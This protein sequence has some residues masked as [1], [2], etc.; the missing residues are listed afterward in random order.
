M[1]T[2][3]SKANMIVRF[4][5][6][7][8]LV[9]NLMK[10]SYMG[11]IRSNTE[12]FH[13]L[14]LKNN[15]IREEVV[16]L[17][18]TMTGFSG[19]FLKNTGQKT[20]FIRYYLE[21]PR[22]SVGFGLSQLWYSIVSEKDKSDTHPLRGERIAVTHLSV[23]FS[24]S[25]KILPVAEDMT[26]AHNNF[27]YGSDETKW[28]YSN[29]YYNKLIYHNIYDNID[30]VYEIMENQL[31]YNFIV[32]PGGSPQSIQ[33]QWNGPVTLENLPTGIQI[34]VKSS[35]LVLTDSSP[36]IYQ[37]S[38]NHPSIEGS[39]RLINSHTYGFLIPSYDPRKILIIDPVILVT[40]TYV[41]GVSTDRGY[42]LAVDAAG[43]AWVTGYTNSDNFPVTP[44]AYDSVYNTTDIFLLKYNGNSGDLEYSTFIGGTDYEMAYSLAFDASGDVWL[45][46]ETMS[47]DF[48]LTSDAIDSQ[49]D[50]VEVFL[51][52]L[53]RNGSTLLYSTFIG[54]TDVE[55]GQAIIIDTQ[56]N[57]WLTGVT[58]SL[59]FPTTLNAYDNSSN[60]D[61]DLFL[62][63]LAANG[64]LILYST[65]IGGSGADLPSDLLLDSNEDIWLAGY[66]YSTDF[67][68]T[69]NAT[70]DIGVS[71]EG[72]LLKINHLT[73]NLSFSTYLGGG[74]YDSIYSI[75]MD[76]ANNLW[77]TG[78]TSSNTF[79]TTPDAINK[80]RNGYDDAFIVQFSPINGSILYSTFLGGTDDDLGHSIVIDLWDNI[81]IGGRTDST[82]F[83]ITPDALNTTPLQYDDD[84]F[85]LG[86]AKN[87]STLLYS[88]FLRGDDT[89]YF[90]RMVIDS[91]QN[92][93]FTGATESTDFPVTKNSYNRS[94]SGGYD[95]VISSFAIHSIPTNP[96]YLAAYET[97]DGEVLLTWD[98][99]AHDGHSPILSYRI[100]RNTSTDSYESY[101][102]ST[103]SHHFIDS[104]VTEGITYYYIVTAVNEYG[105]SAISNE[106]SLQLSLTLTPP[107]PPENF[108]VEEHDNY[109]SL[110]WDPPIID[111]GV[112]ITSYHIYRGTTSGSYLL[113][114]VT[115]NE[116]FNDTT[117][118]LETTYFYVV[119]ALNSIG[120]SE[121]SDEV[122]GLP[123]G[124]SV[125]P[126]TVSSP[127]Q[128]PTAT[129][130][131]N[132][133][134]LSWSIPL[135]DGGSPITGYHVYRGTSSGQYVLIF[136]TPDTF[137]NDTMVFGGITYFYVVAAINSV[138]ES[139][140]SIEVS[141]TSTAS[142][143]T[144][145]STTTVTTM[146][147][148]TMSG[149]STSDQ[150]STTTT[151]TSTITPGWI[152]L[153]A[154]FVL[155]FFRHR[156]KR[157]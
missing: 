87:G 1:K 43:D 66:T 56:G 94:H 13:S 98:Q 54:G 107:S 118:Q 74:G 157:F 131:E 153:L 17:E 46:G 136:I 58:M 104:T 48:P 91:D 102:A 9:I 90:P 33:I 25:N 144:Q 61:L 55:L 73:G 122:Q 8:L 70:D 138:G 105:E 99:P 71:N 5:L 23:V 112:A 156:T 117:V 143:T 97:I 147:T 140:F 32:Y 92:L 78:F 85:V 11:T 125:I 133:I 37:S 29:P 126:P 60:G 21:S 30:L 68:L 120:E 77:L 137:Y 7:S 41:G 72:I 12:A 109:L 62:V 76:S 110:S 44:D 3:E 130:G 127:P 51:L 6:I 150:K 114:G 22:M 4:F 154:L 59:D 50:S 69:P 119:I 27:F 106:I 103:L 146:T 26:G 83:P 124:Q 95:V 47:S 18:K 52:K 24:G 101:V 145:T 2:L 142:V 49:L 79:P 132:S 19:G 82:D 148:T 89:E 93:W 40:S 36:I 108:S 96:R 141:A 45:T 121:F 113:L 28:S 42:D 10:I 31:K 64:S 34:S 129:T 63:N 16:D 38:T 100:Y 151:P 149:E 84:F 116:F 139:I 65:Y 39:F 57:L 128:N 75:A 135:D 134:Y 35:A 152:V 123:T 111:G 81:W 15:A 88:T 80:S 115:I 155:L 53:A 67:P 14:D 86:M 20:D